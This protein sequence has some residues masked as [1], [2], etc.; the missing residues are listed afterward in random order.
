MKGT[1]VWRNR[2]KVVVT[3][4]IADGRLRG[5]EGKDLERHVSAAYPFGERAMHPYK[6]WLDEVAVQMGR[7]PV[8]RLR[9]NSP[10][11]LGQGR[12]F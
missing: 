6:I 12:L 10:D 11:A 2:A 3:R 7:K 4:A 9:K 8:R 1:S 5:L